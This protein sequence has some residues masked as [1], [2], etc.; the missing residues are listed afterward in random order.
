M[1]EAADKKESELAVSFVIER[2]AYR[3]EVGFR[4]PPG[5]T[6]IGGSSGAGKSTLLDVVAGLV[7]PTEG[8]IALGNAI[9]F[10]ATTNVPTHE[11]RLAYVFQ[12]LALFPHMTAL[13][14]VMYGASGDR[15]EREERARAM[16]GRMKVSH[17]EKRLPKTLSG[18]EAQRV[19]L[20]RAFAM[21]PKV[22]LLD[23][24]FSALDVDLRRQLLLE[25]RAFAE[26]LA[27][28]FL[29]VTHDRED[30]RLIGNRLVLL[31]SGRVAATGPVSEIWR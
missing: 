31:E 27:V 14:N 25:V 28:P 10:D 2:A 21:S 26:E 8:R 24:P 18:G 30:A 16:L 17:V 22:V 20:A 15:Q 13:A 12:S 6:V 4:A 5:V 23:E 1:S 9:W 3:L 19:A 29:L 11:R 7:A